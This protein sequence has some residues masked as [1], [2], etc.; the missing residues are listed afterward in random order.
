MKVDIETST[1]IIGGR[2]FPAVGLVCP[3]EAEPPTEGRWDR[4][5]GGPGV[6]TEPYPFEGLSVYVPLE[7]G[8]LVDVESGRGM[9]PHADTLYVMLY[10]RTCEWSTSPHGEGL[11]SPHMMA[12]VGKQIVKNK[13]PA[14]NR[15][16]MPYPRELWNWSDAEEEWVAEHLDRL[17]KLECLTPEGPPVELIRLA[18]LWELCAEGV[19]HRLNA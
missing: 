7:N 14:P 4:V 16:N 9:N 2:R 6:P 3:E 19:R 17:A 5:L 8:V 15:L 18:E 11:W 13:L 10:A 12:R 1:V